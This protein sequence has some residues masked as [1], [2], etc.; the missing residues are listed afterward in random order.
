MLPLY[1]L[2]QIAA[3]ILT[4]QEPSHTVVAALQDAAPV[5]GVDMVEMA[6]YPVHL[7][8]LFVDRQQITRTSSIWIRC[9][10]RRHYAHMVLVYPLG[11]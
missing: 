9:D 3:E 2:F 8:S 1:L 10:L 6:V 7:L 5:R 11:P 4:R